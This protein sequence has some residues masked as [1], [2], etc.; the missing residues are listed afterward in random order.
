LFLWPYRLIC[1]CLILSFVFVSPSSLFNFLSCHRQEKAKNKRPVLSCLVLS[2][3]VLCNEGGETE[4]RHDKTYRG[5]AHRG[6]A[7]RPLTLP[8]EI[9]LSYRPVF[10]RCRLSAGREGGG[11]PFHCT[12]H[13]LFAHR[14]SPL[15]VLFEAPPPPSS[16]LVIAP[17][18]LL[19]SLLFFFPCHVMTCPHPHPLFW[20]G[21]ICLTSIR[22]IRR[23]DI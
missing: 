13:H 9:H 2:F 23:T 3:N 8:A 20:G 6:K 11:L 10:L 4:A 22:E 17:P 12:S 14:L 21:T 7:A 5:K 19:P 18:L 15:L 1:H 16:D